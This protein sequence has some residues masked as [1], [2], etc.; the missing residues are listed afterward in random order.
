M[1]SPALLLIIALSHLSLSDQLETEHVLVYK[2]NNETSGRPFNNSDIV[3][4]WWKVDRKTPNSPQLRTSTSLPALSLI[5]DF[6]HY[7][8]E[9]DD[10]SSV[11]R[12]LT[13][14]EHSQL[15]KNEDLNVELESPFL[16]QTQNEN[17]NILIQSPFL[18][19]ATQDDWSENLHAV[20]DS[21]DDHSDIANNNDYGN[22]E[23]I[24]VSSYKAVLENYVGGDEEE[25]G[26]FNKIRRILKDKIN[27]DSFQNIL[28][29]ANYPLG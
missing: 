2:S 15:E 25:D 24:G 10:H 8:S 21:L 19:T 13:S 28:Q 12:D 1:L 14:E 17:A 9:D 5:K 29:Q 11:F 20:D 27:G 16:V 6:F 4:P 23:G 18:V 22:L 3:T 7:D 26:L